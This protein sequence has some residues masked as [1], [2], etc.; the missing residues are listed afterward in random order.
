LIR[1]VDPGK[2]NLLIVQR[3]IFAKTA[4]MFGCCNFGLLHFAGSNRFRKPGMRRLS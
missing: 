1:R 4:M 3:K 2:R